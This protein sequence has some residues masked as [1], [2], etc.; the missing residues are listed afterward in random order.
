MAQ[1][2]KIEKRLRAISEKLR[3]IAVLRASVLGRNINADEQHKLD[4]QAALEREQSALKAKLADQVP[5]AAGAPKDDDSDDGP[6]C[7]ICFD[8]APRD[9]LIAPCA[10]R[11]SI[12]YVHADCLREWISMTANSESRRTCSQCGAMYKIH[13]GVWAKRRRVLRLGLTVAAFVALSFLLATA[14]PWYARCVTGGGFMKWSKSKVN[15]ILPPIAVARIEKLN[16]IPAKPDENDDGS[17]VSRLAQVGACRR[18]G[19]WH[20]EAAFT[21]GT[22]KLCGLGL[23]IFLASKVFWWLAEGEMALPVLVLDRVLERFGVDALA[24]AQV[25]NLAVV[26]IW[27]WYCSPWVWGYMPRHDESLGVWLGSLLLGMG[28]VVVTLEEALEGAELALLERR[29]GLRAADMLIYDRK[30]GTYH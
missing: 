26:G 17:L 1:D 8:D 27:Y 22:A 13:K 2:E 25:I 20:V 7:R 24:N 9:M 12:E 16:W 4:Q 28:C 21:Y 3:Q 29:G 11:G 15:L 18:R 10:C 14:L 23:N 30:R 19:E 5:A 6:T